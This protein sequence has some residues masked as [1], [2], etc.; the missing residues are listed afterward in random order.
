MILIDTQK[1]EFSKLK[2]VRIFGKVSHEGRYNGNLL[3]IGL[4][5][6]GSKTVLN[7]KGMLVDN[8][9]PEDNISFLMVDSDIPAM[10]ATIKDS[11]E[12]LGF[13]AM[14]VCS[15][16]RPNAENLL[17][18]GIDNNP[19]HPNLASWMASDF[20]S[21]TI[22]PR[23]TGGNR[24]IGR[25]M[26]SN[27]Y[28]D[29]SMLLFDKLEEARNKV[30]V[31]YL[32][33]IIVTGLGGGTGSGILSDLTYNLR[34]YSKKMRWNNVRIGAC[35]MMPDVLF[36]IRAIYD[37][38]EKMQIMKANAYATLKE[39]DHYMNLSET[40]DSY[41]FQSTTHRFAIRDNIFD[42]CMLVSGKR[43]SQGYIPDGFVYRDTAKYLYKLASNKYIGTPDKY[44]ERRLL[45]DVF[46]DNEIKTISTWKINNADKADIAGGNCF[47]KVPSEADYRI[48]IKEME[49]I[50]EHEVFAEAFKEINR[51]VFSD[52]RQMESFRNAVSELDRFLDE[53]AGAE[54]SLNVSGL[55]QFGRFQKPVYKMIKK[56]QDTLLQDMM[57]DL[58]KMEAELPK[59]VKSI[60]NKIW[61]NL[62]GVIKKCML[63]KGPFAAIELIGAKGF[64]PGDGKQ[65][66]IPEIRKLSDKLEK[67][68]PS[69][70]YER[71]IE[72]I[73]TIVA[74]R[75]FTFP[76]AK[77]ETENGYY[78][79]CIKH[80]LS[81][82]RNK[83]MDELNSQDVLGDTVRWLSERA[84]RLDEIF[85]Q[86]GE[87]LNN[88]IEDLSNI[89]KSAVN[90]LLKR[91]SHHN[92]LPSDYISEKRIADFRNGIV[93]FLLDNETNIDNNKVV[94]VK[95]ALEKLYRDFFGGIGAFGP[96]KML[97]VAFSE[98][99]LVEQDLN[100]MFGSP[101]NDRRNNVMRL[102][103]EAFVDDIK[104]EEQLCVLK[105]K[106]E[107]ALPRRKYI[108]VPNTMP[109]F[110][111]AVKDIL[112]SEPYNEKTDAITLNPG[113]IEI[114]IDDMIVGVPLAMMDCIEEL[115]MAYEFTVGYKGLHIDERN[116]DMR[117]KFNELISV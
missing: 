92:F 14:E 84:E 87:D 11:K 28:E 49:N 94:P 43:D 113:E 26:F 34:A 24:Q 54:I 45:R 81:Q 39:I 95:D 103:A 15:I 44:G 93:R 27:A 29:M 79:A 40:E 52:D 72:S 31:G 77:R 2:D 109:Y 111:E 65:G 32:D 114:S 19:V 42:A 64:G 12:H 78:D 89:G 68:E 1:E 104:A 48:P 71:I 63:E 101:K 46:F 88:S 60:K 105:G 66:M 20:P 13:N 23:G 75:F 97:S 51:S 30:K 61:S 41:V 98:K 50:C 59:M 116:V 17:A 53:P 21:I 36:G 117:K 57:K 47:Y 96:E 56:R 115:Q 35:L 18:N 3:V 83:I 112:V 73:H 4:G 22:T 76:S 85:S 55:V 38:T 91:A 107:E 25:L 37:N 80:I 82:E 69:S 74:K 62:D 102:A 110:S 100:V 33:V 9:T 70:E 67:Y 58:D 99:R 90:N 6:V 7:L 16:Y 5:G 8:I 106:A 86:F 108:S 10:E